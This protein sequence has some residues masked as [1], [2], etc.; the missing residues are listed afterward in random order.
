MKNNN[1]NS[2]MD[3]EIADLRNHAK[4]PRK[5]EYQEFEPEQKRQNFAHRA[6]AYM[7]LGMSILGG[8]SIGVIQNYIP[9]EGVFLKNA[10]RF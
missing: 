6:L 9:A 8:S 5:Q 3:Q 1:M 10:W 2:E 4:Q 7:V